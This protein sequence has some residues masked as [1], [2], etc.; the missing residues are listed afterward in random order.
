M[1]S[2]VTMSRK[3]ESMPRGHRS[4]RKSFDPAEIESE[5]IRIRSL[6]IDELRSLWR[7]TFGKDAPVV[8][9]KDLIARVLAWHVQEQAFGGFDR[10]T[11]KILEGYARG[12]PAEPEQFRRLKPGTELVREYRGERHTV[13]IA[14]DGFV[15]R[16]ATYGS[17]TT[18]ARTITGSN[19]NGPRFFGL[20]EKSGDPAAVS[21]TGRQGTMK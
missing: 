16:G 19:W 21:E 9:T 17:L 8:L 4:R 18:I 15:W 5:I 7:A 10:A 11:L 14:P 12:R 13:T 1:A 20:R 3:R 2:A 6:T